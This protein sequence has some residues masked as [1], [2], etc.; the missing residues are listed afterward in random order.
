MSPSTSSHY[1]RSETPVL[2]APGA[3]A[4]VAAATVPAITPS[5]RAPIKSPFTGLG[6][7][8]SVAISAARLPAASLWQRARGD[9]YT[10]LFGADCAASGLSGCGS[11]FATML[12]AVSARVAGLSER[13]MLDQVNRA[14]N[15][16]MTYR[17][18]RAIWGVGDRWATP[19][20]MARKGAG[21][22]ED[23][24]IA[25]YWLLRSLG[26]A[27][28]KLQMVVLQDTRRQLFHAV[29]VVHTASGAYV[30]DNVTNRLQ[31]DTAY[32]QYQP[33]MSFAGGK[34]Y[35]HGFAAGSTAVAAMPRDLSAVA[36]GLGM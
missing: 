12:R 17:S 3:S 30:L 2:I 28:E 15:S 6:V 14:V 21:D 16:A 18:D 7:F 23:F 35:I 33:I 10:A 4:T 1:A 5:P 24:A 22:C 19:V 11:R 27:D 8:G 26:V 36:P 32:A 34:N 25:K 29:L 31:L 9:D 20:E 13:A